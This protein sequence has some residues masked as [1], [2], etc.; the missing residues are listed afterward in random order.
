MLA[1]RIGGPLPLVAGFAGVCAVALVI[2]PR[3]W[4][5]S[6]GAV[7]AATSYGLLGMVMTRPMAGWRTVREAV[8]T[9]VIGGAGAVVVTGYDV[10]LRAYRFRIMV[11]ALTLIAAL[12]LARRL[13]LGFRSLGRRGLVLIV[14]AVVLL[15]MAFG[16]VQAVRHWGSSGV[17]G[18]VGDVHSRIRDWLGASPRTIEALVGFPATIWGVAVR[19]RRR[20]GWWM[21][22]FGS[23]AAAGI[24]TSLVSP[25][26]SFAEAAEATAYNLLIGCVLGLVIDQP[27]PAVDRQTASGAR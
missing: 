9:A 23:L 26:V 8:I 17:V 7:I 18:S 16:Y 15:V 10:S 22:A 11:L 25:S 24:A 19:K 2:E 1:W 20:Q 14:A 27:G 21:S 5:L 13:G 3:G 6:A 4:V 12:A